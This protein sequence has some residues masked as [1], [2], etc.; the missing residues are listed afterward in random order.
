MEQMTRRGESRSKGRESLP[1][2]PFF[3]PASNPLKAG[4][5]QS[6]SFHESLLGSNK[7]AL[8]ISYDYVTKNILLIQNTQ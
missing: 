8:K 4:S 3:S 6:L 2:D 5:P 1:H 7:L